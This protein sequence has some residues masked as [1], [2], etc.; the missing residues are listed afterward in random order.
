MAEHQAKAPH[1]LF[2]G[3]RAWGCDVTA[4]RGKAAP[5]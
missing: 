5:Y 3:G 4:L 2:L 1:A